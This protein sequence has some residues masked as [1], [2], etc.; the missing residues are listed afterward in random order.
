MTQQGPVLPGLDLATA[1][2]LNFTNVTPLVNA[3]DN[4]VPYANFRNFLSTTVVLDNNGVLG[5]GTEINYFSLQSA[6][7]TNIW[8]IDPFLGK[9]WEREIMQDDFP[10]GNYYFDH[11]RKPISTVQ[12]GNM[13][14]IINP[15][16]LNAAAVAY[17]G[18][19]ALA[20]VSQITNA[21][22]LYG[23]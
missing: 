11:R 18:W 22:S 6:N 5:T 17:V 20:I 16:G 1:Y 14:L 3:Q 15:V 7:Y 13:Q 21:G 19:E 2:L 4:P 12:Y 8:K 9:L 10:L 23:V